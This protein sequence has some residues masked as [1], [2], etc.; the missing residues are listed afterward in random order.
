MADAKSSDRIAISGATYLFDHLPIHE[1]ARESHKL[2]VVNAVR[3]AMVAFR[4]SLEKK[5]A[6]PA[7]LMRLISGPP[8][9]AG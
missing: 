4:D 9:G 3:F 6:D 1:S 7:A 2:P 5:I 8:P